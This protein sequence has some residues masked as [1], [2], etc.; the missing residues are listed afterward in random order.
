[1]VASAYFAV[2]GTL[3]WQASQA[4]QAIAFIPLRSL[5][6]KPRLQN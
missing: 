1:M 2:I 3:P 4:L 6:S 5:L